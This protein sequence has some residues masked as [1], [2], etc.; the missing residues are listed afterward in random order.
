ML[1]KTMPFAIPDQFTDRIQRDMSDAQWFKK[2]NLP[3]LP[4]EISISRIL[5]DSMIADSPAA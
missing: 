2:E 3:P 5:I 4:P 1:F